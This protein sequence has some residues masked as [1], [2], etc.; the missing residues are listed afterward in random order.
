MTATPDSRWFAVGSSAEASGHAAGADATAQALHPE[1]TLRDDAKLLIAFHT[2]SRDPT[3]VLEGINATSGGVPLIGC[4]TAGAL[5]TADTGLDDVVVAAIGGQGFTVATRVATG[6]SA[7]HREAGAEVSTCAESIGTAP[8]RVLLLFT[9]G[10]SGKQQEIIRGA[11]A[12]VGASVP[13]VGGGAGDGTRW[14]RTCQFH[15]TDVRHDAV[16]AA[17]IGSSGPFGIGV[18]HGWR[19]IGTP[20]IVTRS[21]DGRVYELGDEPALDVYL[22]R[23][24]APAEVHDDPVAFRTFAMTHPLG[25]VRR[26]GGDE[27]RFVAD[28]DFAE[29]ALIGLAD[30]PQGVLVWF[31]EGDRDTILSAT[32]AACLAAIDGLSGR[33]PIG[34]LAFDCAARRLVLGETG[35][36]DESDRIVKHAATAPVAGFYTCGEIAR[37]RGINGYHNQTLVVLALS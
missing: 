1:G 17:A 5:A 8:Y 29:R 36:R 14:E 9:D 37:V 6:V 16:V 12:Q 31:T 34:L 21:V 3:D 13:L 30:V 11:Y 26:G 4:S 7:R 20:M 22:R 28:A 15:N 27:M 25:L 24:N 32:D 33:S 18:Y 35:A 2:G 19:Q 23:L 10:L